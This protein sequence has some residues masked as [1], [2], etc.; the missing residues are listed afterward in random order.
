MKIGERNVSVSIDGGRIVRTT[1]R[2]VAI[3]LFVALIVWS[4][5]GPG[6]YASKAFE[7]AQNPVS[8]E[9]AEDA[10]GV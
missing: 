9:Q 1:L 8:T 3:L 7:D 4:M 6:F 5:A 10:P 2:L